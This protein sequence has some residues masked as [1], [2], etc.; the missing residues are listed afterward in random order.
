MVQVNFSSPDILMVG[1]GVMGMLSALELAEAG[2]KVL[3][4]DQGRAGLEAS[5]AGGGIISPLYP[6]RYAPP[7]TALATWSQQV[8]PDLIA[9][10]TDSTGIDSELSANG[11]LVTATDERDQALAWGAGLS[12]AVIEISD[13]EARVLEPH[14][15]LDATPLFRHSTHGGMRHRLRP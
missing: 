1:A 8:F 7:I 11:M 14:V 15:H 10:L 9:S 3:M 12:R 13:Q 5:W 4:I 6:W 2:Q